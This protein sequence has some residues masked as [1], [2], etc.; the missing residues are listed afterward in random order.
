[1]AIIFLSLHSQMAYFMVQ[2]M[3]TGGNAPWL[4]RKVFG[5]GVIIFVLPF[6]CFLV[7]SVALSH[8]A[9]LVSVL[10]SDEY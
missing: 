9:S 4:K 6:T 2:M 10:D 8:N 7:F 1:M 3:A 5:L